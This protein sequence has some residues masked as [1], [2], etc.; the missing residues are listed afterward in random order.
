MK[1][2][3]EIVAGMSESDR[4]SAIGEFEAYQVANQ[5]Q[6]HGFLIGAVMDYRIQHKVLEG[7]PLV[8][9]VREMGMELY[10]FYALKYLEKDDTPTYGTLS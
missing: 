8:N 5:V 7:L 10:K 2:M 3:K 1:D 4:R 9:L 6:P